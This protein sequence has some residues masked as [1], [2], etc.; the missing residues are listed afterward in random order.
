MTPTP[1]TSST[2]T[3]AATLAALRK[4]DARA[5]PAGAGSISATLTDDKREYSRSRRLVTCRSSID[6]T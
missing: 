1:R 6:S 3:L 4:G 2:V 5:A